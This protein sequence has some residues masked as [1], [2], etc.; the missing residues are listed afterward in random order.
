MNRYINKILLIVCIIVFLATYSVLFSNLL[1]IG[2]NELSE[3]SKDPGRSLP[4]LVWNSVT[5][6]V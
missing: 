1:N 2:E 4:I 3:I 5:A 6:G